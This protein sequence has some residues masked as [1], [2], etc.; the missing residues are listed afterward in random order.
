MTQA[1][2]TYSYR[3]YL[4]TLLNYGPA[5]KKYQL[6]AVLFY[7]DTAGKMDTADPTLAGTGKLFYNAGNDV[8]R[9]EY[10]GGYAVHVADLKPDMCGSSPH[11]NVV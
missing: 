3:A 4:E 8:T 2:A 6:T 11:F 1:T 5:A 10:T 7:K 9:D